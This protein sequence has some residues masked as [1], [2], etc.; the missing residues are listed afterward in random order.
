[1]IS[2]SQTQIALYLQDYFELISLMSTYPDAQPYFLF[3]MYLTKEKRQ[4]QDCAD[5]HL[6]HHRCGVSSAH[7]FGADELL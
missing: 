3:E 1:M 7:L 6:C 5:S 2:M 4:E